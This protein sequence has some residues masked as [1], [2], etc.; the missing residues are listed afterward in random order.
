MKML[1]LLVAVPLFT[2]AVAVAG[3]RLR[4]LVLTDLSTEPD[5]ESLVRFLAYANEFDAERLIAT[6]STHLKNAPREDIL[7]HTIENRVAIHR[8]EREPP[9]RDLSGAACFG[10]RRAPAPLSSRP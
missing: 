4:V 1:F 6:T 7:H 10:V 8:V 2:S 3:D 9:P 5:D